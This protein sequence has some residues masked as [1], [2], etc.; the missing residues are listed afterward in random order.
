MSTAAAE[1]LGGPQLRL[2]AYQ[3]HAFPAMRIVPAPVSRAWMDETSARFAR[4][5]L[6][7]LMAN[8]SGWHLLSSHL[9]RIT[10]DGGE[11]CSSIKIEFPDGWAPFP[12]SSHFGHGI[13]TWSVPY[14]FRTPPGYNLL[15]RGPANWP[16]DGACPLEGS[17]EADWAVSS[18]TMNWKLTRPG[19]TV[20]FEKDEPVCMILPQRRGELESFD[21]EVRPLDADPD[22]AHGFRSWSESRRQFLEELGTSSS[23]ETW[24]KH[25][26]KGVTQE[27]LYAEGHQTQLRLNEFSKRT[28][29]S[30]DLSTVQRGRPEPTQKKEGEHN[31]IRTVEK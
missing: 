26:F 3:T 30:A 17:V 12:V 20:T 19:I 23:T 4:R 14:L 2:I 27:G 11:A 13:V 31:A 15:V 22:I 25:Y 5:C 8:Q 24:Q 29:D 10:W 9:V 28:H 1:R 21:P 16:K 7:L 6:P 18:F